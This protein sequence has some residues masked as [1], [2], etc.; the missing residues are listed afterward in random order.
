[1]ND[2]NITLPNFKLG[3]VVSYKHYTFKIKIKGYDRLFDIPKH[4]LHLKGKYLYNLPENDKYKPFE[5]QFLIPKDQI[6]NVKVNEYWSNLKIGKIVKLYMNANNE[7][8]DYEC[9]D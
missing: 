1:M 5:K 9:I 8:I 4:K 7:I 3:K 2:F 6:F